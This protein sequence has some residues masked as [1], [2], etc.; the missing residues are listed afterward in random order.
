MDILYIKP[1]NDLKLEG[2]MLRG[3]ISSTDTV[4]VFD[5]FH[6]IIGFYLSKHNNDFFKTIFDVSKNS[7]NPTEY[8]SVGSRLLMKMY[9]NMDLLLSKHKNIDVSNLPMSYIYSYD[10]SKINM[11]F[12]S[13]DDSLITDKTIGIHW[14]NGSNISK[15]FNNIYNP[16]D[17][18]ITNV[19]TN[20]INKLKIEE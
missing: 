6:H 14:Y 4:I 10:D 5:G 3:D 16:K 18:N 7:L 12:N 19:L 2:T 9:P 13:I 11:L 20:L 1:L 8:Q 17:K 15:Q